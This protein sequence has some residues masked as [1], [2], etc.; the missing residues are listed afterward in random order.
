MKKTIFV[1]IVLVFAS[2]VLTACGGIALNEPVSSTQQLAAETGSSDE[3]QVPGGDEP[4]E[5]GIERSAEELATFILRAEHVY[6]DLVFGELFIGHWDEASEEWIQSIYLEE[7]PDYWLESSEGHFQGF[8][9]QRW[10]VLPSSGFTSIAELNAAVH[11]YW[12]EDF[13]VFTDMGTESIDYAE[14]DGA[15]YFFP[16]MA[17]GVG[18]SFAGVIWELAQFEVLHQ[19]DNN[20]NVR[21][22]VYITSYGELL[23]ATLKWEIVDGKI[24]VRDVEWGEVIL[25]RDAPEAIDAMIAS[26]RWTEEQVAHNWESGWFEQQVAWN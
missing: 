2:A 9:M 25:W 3:E 24:V 15:L 14:F 13:G 17:S 19:A 1:I 4:L 26:G 12:S 21:A 20:M 5:S 23:R 7:A 16:A 22:E 18:D 8:Y 11:E 10:R 6:R